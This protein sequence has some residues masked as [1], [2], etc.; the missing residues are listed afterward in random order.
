[1]QVSDELLELSGVD[2]PTIVSSM[3]L[4]GTVRRR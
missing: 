3:L 1:M 4:K 2:H